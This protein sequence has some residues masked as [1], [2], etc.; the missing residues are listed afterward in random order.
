MS[1]E[2]TE[3]TFSVRYEKVAQS[4]DMLDV[5]RLLAFD[6]I[7]NPYMSVGEF[8]K[9]LSDSNLEILMDLVEEDE[10]KV[11]SRYAELL[12]IAE[13]LARAEGEDEGD[14]DILTSRTNAF[15]SFL[16]IESLA[17]KGLVK[18]YRENMSFGEDMKD[19]VIVERL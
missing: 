16:V 5:T 3:G 7:T 11:G 9:N 18:V 13:M 1:E 15:T 19:K 4:K 12:L 17:R 6:L 10:D 8:L 2:G 14:I